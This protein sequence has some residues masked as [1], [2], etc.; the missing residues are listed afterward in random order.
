MNS[1]NKR[2]ENL[3]AQ[4]SKLMEKEKQP[5]PD[6]DKIRLLEAKL[7]KMEV[8]L[9]SSEEAAQKLKAEIHGI[10][11]HQQ[12][13]NTKHTTARTRK[14]SLAPEEEQP[15]LQRINQKIELE[16]KTL[17]AR[18]QKKIDGL[19]KQIQELKTNQTD[20]S[21]SQLTRAEHTQD[22]EQLQHLAD[23]LKKKFT[24]FHQY[25]FH[26]KKIEKAK[27]FKQIRI[28]RSKEKTTKLKIILLT[29]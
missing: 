9:K 23:E 2:N 12:A 14:G 6:Q 17:E 20:S 10:Q 29:V 8:Q 13:P 4:V 27:K 7:T 24:L 26:Q 5:H 18:Y 28:F 1:I 15:I 19:E 3:Q 16:F 25:R 11:A 21:K 22:V